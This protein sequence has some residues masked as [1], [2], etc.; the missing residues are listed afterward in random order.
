MPS[1]HVLEQAVSRGII[2]ADQGRQIAAL[3]AEQNQVW[4]AAREPVSEPQPV[5]L[6]DPD[7]DARTDGEDDE[8]FRFLTGFNDVFLALGVGMVLYGLSISGTTATVNGLMI[9]LVVLWLLAEVLAAR[10]KRALPSMI[11]AGAFVY[12]AIKLAGLQFSDL[13][14]GESNI[15]EALLEDAT[16][17]LPFSLAG[18]AAALIFY[19]RF[20]LP[21][22]VFLI[23]GSL[24]FL[25]FTLTFSYLR[26]DITTYAIPI[27]LLTGL[28]VFAAAMYFDTSDINRRTRLSDNAFWLHLI[29]S[30]LIVHSIMWQAAIWMG[31]GDP[32]LW[33]G[34]RIGT[35]VGLHS[36]AS[37][38]AIIV[39]AIFIFVMVVALVI[40]RR[41][42][43]VSSLIYVSAAVAFYVTSQGAVLSAAT[44]VPVIIGGGIIAV[45]TGWRPLRRAVFRFLPLAAVEP[46]VPPLRGNPV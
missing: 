4:G 23:A 8:A 36:I 26:E 33:S 37:T 1:D 11:I 27:L 21:F 16:R 19:V 38:L 31:V 43:L 41:A 14:F 2:T 30:P 25:V 40:D 29:A 24:V 6:V 3:D 7:G 28:S 5:P 35:I 32:E 46:Y 20:R 17:V 44:F 18:T 13:V 15:F 22:A 42:M 9:T 34:N 12:L 39:L 10:L 45:G